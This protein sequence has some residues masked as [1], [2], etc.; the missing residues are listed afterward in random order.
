MSGIRFTLVT[1]GPSD[2][3]LVEHLSWLLAENLERGVTVQRQWADL[4]SLREKPKGLAERITR[5]LDLYPCDLL[6]V[7]RDA[8]RENSSVRFQEIQQAVEEAKV[9]S[10]VVGVVPVRMTEAWLLFEVRAIRLAAG[11]PNGQAVLPIPSLDYE[12]IPDPKQTL[13]DVLQVA[14]GL[15]G[16]RL[17]KFSASQAT[18][19]VAEYIDDFSPLRDLPAF[20]VLEAKLREVIEHYGWVHT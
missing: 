10:P 2:K 17:R 18:Y 11:N 9:E 20:Q 7:H 13:R 19:R 3:V 1:D 14:S 12:R 15:S 4:R 16:R 5:A 8:E 6:F